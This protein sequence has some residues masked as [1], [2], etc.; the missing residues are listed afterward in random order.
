[1]NVVSCGVVSIG[2][3]AA[4]AGRVFDELRAQGPS[5]LRLISQPQSVESSACDLLVIPVHC[6]NFDAVAAEI[7]R[8]KTDC[9]A[10][11]IIVVCVDLLSENI[12]ALLSAGAVDFVS[13]PFAGKELCTRIQR[14]AGLLPHPRLDESTAL[15]TARAHDLIGSSPCFVKQVS[16]LATIAGCNAGVLLL[17]E[18]GTGKEV[19]AR[20]IHY[21]SNRASGPRVAVNCGAIPVDLMESELFGCTRGAFTSAYA[22]RSGLVREAEGGTLFLDDI[23][24]LPLNAQAKLLRFLQEKEY[25]PVGGAGICRADVRVIAASNRDLAD[26]TRRGDIRQD[27]YFRLNVLSITLPALRERREDIPA[28]AKHFV[29]KCC[30]QLNRPNFGLTPDALKRLMIHDWP[31]NVRELHNVIE[32]AVLFS[33]ESLIRAADL[34]LPDPGG[35]EEAAE[36]F[37]DAKARTVIAFERN[38]IERLLSANSGNVTRAAEAAKKDRRAFFELMR[39]HRITPERFRRQ[40]GAQE[41]MLT[42]QD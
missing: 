5:Q 9:P 40:F 28:L 29:E 25:R 20:A 17:G 34:N 23:E 2:S 21:L 42:P 14:A 10:C 30:R 35:V 13:T 12:A 15:S 7:E 1:M 19:F 3:Q 24:S 38:Y 26:L 33:R 8:L 22:A 36:S 41:S 6:D 32:R 27:L 39:K 18:T 11:S 4:F 16:A 31:G 37:R